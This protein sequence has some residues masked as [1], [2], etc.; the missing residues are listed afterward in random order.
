[1]FYRLVHTLRT[2]L[3]RPVTDSPEDLIRRDSAAIAQACHRA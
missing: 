3:A 2:T 1:M